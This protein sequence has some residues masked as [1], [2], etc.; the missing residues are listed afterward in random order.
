MKDIDTIYLTILHR[1]LVAL[2]NAA[3]AGDIARCRAEAEHLHEM[4]TLVGESNLHRH[5]HYARGTRALYLEWVV[6]QKSKELDDWVEVWYRPEWKK[7]DRIL[8][9][10]DDRP[11]Q[12]AV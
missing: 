6:S 11:E 3:E 10:D 7:I 1:G 9:L 4:P 12:G 5:L 2:R 8:G